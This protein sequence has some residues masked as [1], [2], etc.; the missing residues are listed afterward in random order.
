MNIYKSIKTIVCFQ[1][2]NFCYRD[3]QQNSLNIFIST[4]FLR[5]IQIILELQKP[6]R[7]LIKLA[8]QLVLQNSTVQ[9]LKDKKNH[10]SIQ[11]DL[12]SLL[13]TKRQLYYT[14]KSRSNHKQQMKYQQ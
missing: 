9:L 12:L 14:F 1:I 7:Q 2:P 10:F 8:I 3:S 11:I 5:L 4:G 6:L 13:K